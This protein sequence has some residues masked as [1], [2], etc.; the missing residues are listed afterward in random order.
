MG[1]GPTKVDTAQNAASRGPYETMPLRQDS[2]TGSE[3]SRGLQ[4]RSGSDA[5]AS[6]SKSLQ[7]SDMTDQ[8]VR[9]RFMEL[10]KDMLRM[11]FVGELHLE[12]DSIY[13]EAIAIPQVARS[14]KWNR[15]LTILA[16][17]S[18]LF[19]I[20]NI[21]VQGALIL[22]IGE[23]ANVMDVLAG[24]VHLCDYAKDMELC[25]GGPDCE[26]PGG[27][28]FSHER[29]YS[30]DLWSTRNYVRDAFLDLF[31]EKQAE[32][33]ANV[34]PGEYGLENNTCRL[35]CNFL[36]ILAEAKELSNILN[37]LFI[38]ILT[39]TGSMSW[40]SVKGGSE[41]TGLDSLEF[42]I[43]G[44]PLGWKL[45]NFLVV[46][47]PK[48]FLWYYTMWMGF[49]FLMET[50]EI[51]NLVLGAVAMGFVLD[52]DE[53]IFD[54]MASLPAKRILDSLQ[55]YKF[56]KLKESD[57]PGPATWGAV[58][59]LAIPRRLLIAVIMFV[60]FLARYYHDSCSTA[61][62][63]SLVSKSMYR[64]EVSSYS[65][66]YFIFGGMPQE[67]EPFWTMPPR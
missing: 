23:A 2:R 63:G 39:P 40:V 48:F 52:I 53:I 67:E 10:E 54:T 47:V 18:Y 33:M 55:P 11:E 37:F 5:S 31:P 59:L 19:L 6:S 56:E 24:K 13:G 45:F 49:K 35:L 15:I 1:S 25:P 50:S 62:D 44:M 14:C 17:R 32:I 66:Q 28:Q 60:F 41:E 4:A 16:L 22:F 34:D 20:F 7:L 65:L 61:A 46:I 30:F 27:T 3:T 51:V 21:A 42:K 9:E 26:G 58:A 38:L 36:F 43:T 8:E 29:I 12:A 64:P 57:T